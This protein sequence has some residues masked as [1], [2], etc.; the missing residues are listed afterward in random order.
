VTDKTATAQD[1]YIQDAAQY[2]KSQAQG[3]FA[4]GEQWLKDFYQQ[5]TQMYPAEAKR[6][7]LELD[8]LLKQYR[9]EQK[10]KGK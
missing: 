5:R 7:Q 8:S 10:A 6:Y 2:L 4:D 3:S 9:E 1:Q